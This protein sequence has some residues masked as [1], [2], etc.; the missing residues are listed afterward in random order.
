M[1]EFCLK[2]FNKLN[3]FNFKSYQ[4]KFFSYKDICED[5][6]KCKKLVARVNIL[7]EIA[8]ERQYKKRDKM[9]KRK[10]G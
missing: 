7:G 3:E 9:N 8:E 10:R 1:A 4:V 2:C 6:G 5:C